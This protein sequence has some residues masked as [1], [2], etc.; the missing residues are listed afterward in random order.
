MRYL[1]EAIILRDALIK[2]M[3]ENKDHRDIAKKLADAISK[4]E[5][6]VCE[7]AWERQRKD[8]EMHE[9]EL[10]TVR[11]ATTRIL[12]RHIERIV[13]LERDLKLQTGGFK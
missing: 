4:Y 1:A 7:K 2:I 8:K 5:I 10:L 9:E 3:S 6:V 12:E 11:Q 13:T